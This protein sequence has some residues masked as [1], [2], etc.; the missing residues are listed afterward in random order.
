MN[1]AI[2]DK[3]MGPVMWSRKYCSDG[4]RAASK[5][6]SRTLKPFKKKCAVCGSDF[7]TWK[8]FKVN[9]SFKCGAKANRDQAKAPPERKPCGRCGEEF[10][11]KTSRGLYCSK[12][13][14]ENVKNPRSGNCR[15][16][17]IKLDNK[18]SVLC[19]PCRKVAKKKERD[20]Y[21]D[22]SN[23]RRIKREW[24]Q[25]PC[26]YC[27]WDKSTCDIHHIAGRKIPNPDD[28]SNLTLACPNCHRLIHDCKIGDIIPL[29]ILM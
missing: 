27:G 19:G 17:G 24:S 26:L 21:R 4:C 5:R 22:T 18:V 25:R 14:K 15:E 1:C 9:C 20:R 29:S 28:P 10:Q 13:C 3:D 2:C 6:K 23:L 12:K 8:S 7:E 11:P 16:C